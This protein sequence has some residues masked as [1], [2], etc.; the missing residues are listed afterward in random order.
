[1]LS[2]SDHHVERQKQADLQVKGGSRALFKI[3][4]DV[5]TLNRAS[6][7]RAA[8]IARARGRR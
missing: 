2:G 7:P 3:P 1:M 5:R 8:N 4:D 6:V